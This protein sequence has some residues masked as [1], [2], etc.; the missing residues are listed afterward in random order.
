MYTRVATALSF[1]SLVLG[2]QVGTVTSETH[3]SLP[4]EVCTAP[5]SCTKE[6]TTVVLDVSTVSTVSWQFVTDLDSLVQLALDSR[7]QRL[8]QLL[9][10]QRLERDGV[11]RRQ[12]MRGQLRP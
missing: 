11:P 12:D 5:G 8:H 3:P 9:H 7:H 10:G 2:Q 1:A 4:I 6:E